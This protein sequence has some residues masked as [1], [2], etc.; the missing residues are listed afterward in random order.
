M[1]MTP[2]QLARRLRREG[3]KNVTFFESITPEQW[4]LE[5]YSEGA[6]WSVQQI[7][8]HVTSA[9]GSLRRMI[10]RIV[11]EDHPGVPEDFDTDG[12]NARKVE[13]LKESSPADLFELYAERREQTALMAE[14]CS[15]TDLLKEGRHPFLG[16]SQVIEM[17]KLMSLHVQL[18]IRDIR[19]TIKSA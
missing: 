6:A 17:L 19:R 5:V 11:K 18:H 1:T 15:Q 4:D 16:Q 13:E 9:E 12:Y 2:D 3:Q 14:G 7:L 8:V 10:S